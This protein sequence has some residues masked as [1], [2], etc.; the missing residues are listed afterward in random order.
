MNGVMMQISRVLLLVLAVM[1][2][3]LSGCGSSESSGEQ[4]GSSQ[5]V[6]TSAPE[7][8]ALRNIYGTRYSWSQFLGKPFVINFWATWC[9]PCRVE[10][11]AFK[12]LYAEYQ[13]RGLEV[14][15]ISMD[16]SRTVA[17]VVP[18]IEYFQVP[19]VVLYGD[20]RTA[21]E[22]QIGPNIPVTIFFDAAGNETARYVG[23]LPEETLR[24]ELEAL[25][26]SPPQS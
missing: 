6:Q 5:T 22:F 10:I 23:M 21:M 2:I 14:V 15:A 18:F 9:A 17:Q 3:H 1:M 24:R 13:P 26:P 11:P 4:S 25:F 16:D 8:F 7:R 20:E 12:K 19:W